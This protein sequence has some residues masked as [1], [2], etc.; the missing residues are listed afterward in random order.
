MVI[1]IAGTGILMGCRIDRR[2]LRGDQVVTSCRETLP[3][4][5]LHIETSY[6]LE[7]MHLVE[8]LGILGV[9]TPVE[10][11]GLAEAFTHARLTLGVITAPGGGYRILVRIVVV[12]REHIPVSLYIGRIVVAL[13]PD[14]PAVKRLDLKGDLLIE[15]ISLL[16]VMTTVPH[17]DNLCTEGVVSIW[18]K[19]N[20]SRP[21]TSDIVEE[22]TG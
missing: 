16:D 14:G 10:V 2:D 5:R 7:V 20:I 9:E 18:V 12:D 22:E 17:L 19:D 3:F 4:V 21:A 8:E 6:H 13:C 1:P 15:T 11:I